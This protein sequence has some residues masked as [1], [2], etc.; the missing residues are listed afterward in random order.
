M[1]RQ[2]VI[3]RIVDREQKKLNLTETVVAKEEPEL[4]RM[5]CECFGAWDTALLYYIVFKNDDVLRSV[6]P[7]PPFLTFGGAAE[8]SFDRGSWH[9]ISFLTLFGTNPS[10][11]YFMQLT[12]FPATA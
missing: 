2:K 3:R 9:P 10:S 12:P 8:C 5:A 11:G 1:T 7:L 4:L 6:S